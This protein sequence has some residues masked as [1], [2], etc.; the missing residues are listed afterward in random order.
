MLLLPYHTTAGGMGGNNPFANAFGPNMMAKLAAEP[1]FLPY[2]AD[3][4]FVAK[5]NMIQQNP[6]NMQMHL[7]DPKIMD[8]SYRPSRFSQSCSC[9]SVCDVL[10]P[11]TSCI[12][13]NVVFYCR[14]SHF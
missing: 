1:K 8:V 6:N 10:R 12:V 3:P 4:A 9:Q 11:I 5:L 13:D 2:L 14:L 7:S